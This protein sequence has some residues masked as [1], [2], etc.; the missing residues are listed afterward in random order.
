MRYYAD[1]SPDIAATLKFAASQV[2]R[3]SECSEGEAS[4]ST[5][6]PDNIVE[7]AL[8]QCF[9]SRA[10]EPYETRVEVT[11]DTLMSPA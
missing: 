11:I 9:S 7:Y 3:S 6:L 4:Q 5:S 8:A 10:N 2:A 1:H